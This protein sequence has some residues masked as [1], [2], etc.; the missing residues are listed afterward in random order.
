MKVGENDCV[1]VMTHEPNWLLNWYWNSS[2]G[3]NVQHLICDYLKGRC[4]LR[5]A[6][7]LHHYMRHSVTCSDKPAGIDHLLVNGCGGA[8]LHPTHVFKNFD[9]FYNASYECKAAYPSYD[10][11]SK[12]ALANIL[13][14]RKKNW[15]FDF[16]GGF[17]YFI[18]VFSLFPQCKLD[19]ILRDDSWS[20]HLN[21]F[22]GTVWSSYIYML[23]H[24]Y[25]SSVGIL[26]LTVSSY[27]FVPSKI[28][29]KSRAMIGFVHVATHLSAALILMMLMELG[30][31]ICIRHHL[32]AT[33]G[34]LKAVGMRFFF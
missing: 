3:K 10:E 20:G 29:R 14:F 26:I 28:S 19:Q 7:D 17:I 4:K 12:I 34:E 22:L 11:S 15:Q 18:L 9:K 6:G 5:I 31:E 2:S 21:S 16:I 23:Q 24:S 13:K 27:L 25:V 30:I 1:I 32:L 8:F 33:S